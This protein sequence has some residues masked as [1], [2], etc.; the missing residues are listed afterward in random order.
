MHQYGLFRAILR[1]FVPPLA[2]G[3]ALTWQDA[4]EQ[5]IPKKV[6]TDVDPARLHS[7]RQ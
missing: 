4:G 5:E 7:T 1:R 2:G 3:P 6:A